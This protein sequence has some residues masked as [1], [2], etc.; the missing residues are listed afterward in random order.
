MFNLNL[1]SFVQEE[2]VLTGVPSDFDDA[3]DGP[4]MAYLINKFPMFY[5]FTV[6]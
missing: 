1:L 2:N 3:L 5:S 4:V 6:K